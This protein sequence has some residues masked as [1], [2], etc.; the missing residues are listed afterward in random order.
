[1]A[2]DGDI[3]SNDTVYEDKTGDSDTIDSESGRN[4]AASDSGSGND[5]A[6]DSGDIEREYEDQNFLFEKWNTD[7]ADGGDDERNEVNFESNAGSL[8]CS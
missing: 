5:D 7:A 2:R 6:A 4:N 3:G 8:W 1:M